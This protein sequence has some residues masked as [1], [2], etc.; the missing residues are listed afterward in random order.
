MMSISGFP[1]RR[2][3][4]NRAITSS[5]PPQRISGEIKRTSG[6]RATSSSD[7]QGR[8]RPLLEEPA[9]G[10]ETPESLKAANV[11]VGD[12]QYDIH[13]RP[14]SFDPKLCRFE[15]AASFRHIDRFPPVAL[16][17]NILRRSRHRAASSFACR[18]GRQ[19]AIFACF[20]AN[21]IP[22]NAGSCLAEST[23]R[24]LVVDNA[25]GF[26]QRHEKRSC[27][28]APGAHAMFR[29]PRAVQ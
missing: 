29:G 6:S 12:K 15:C 11:V 3:S 13:R 2:S 24:F 4:F 8:R 23:S 14:R 20:A 10:K 9:V 21:T 25:S 22:G 18:V 16:F 26:R 17:A 28:P 1:S 5:P 7:I 19:H 27:C